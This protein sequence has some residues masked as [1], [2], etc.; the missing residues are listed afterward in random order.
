MPIPLRME[1]GFAL[2]PERVAAAITPRTK[3]LILNSPA[4]PTGGVLGREAIERLAEL[5]IAHG[6]VVL[7]DEIYGRILYDDAEHVS[8]ASLP[9]MAE[10]TI[11]LDG[12]SKAYAMTGWRVGTAVVPSWLSPHVGR[13]II[14]TISCVP[15]FVQLGALAAI[16]GPQ[17]GVRAMVEE[18]TARRT[19]VVEGLR[20]IPGIR[21]AWPRG[22]FYAFPEVTGT[23]LDGKTMAD[24][25]LDEAGVSTVAGSA[26]GAAADPFLRIS[27]ATSRERLAEGLRRID[28]FVRELPGR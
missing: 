3:L 24:R 4:N 10:R 2:D 6:L 20:A 26:F 15:A 21:C 16:T 28:A 13:L 12:V 11:V 27:Y 18:F 9:G 7:S 5:A 23:G 1:D 22:A 19:L 14:N 25:L 8:I 17:D